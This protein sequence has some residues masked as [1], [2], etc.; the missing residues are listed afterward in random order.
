MYKDLHAK[1]PPGHMH[2]VEKGDRVYVRIPKFY[3]F[4]YSIGPRWMM[5]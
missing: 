1:T 4:L 5:A 3:D 2:D